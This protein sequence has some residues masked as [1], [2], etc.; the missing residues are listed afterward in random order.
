M[1]RA[2]ASFGDNHSF[3]ETLFEQFVEFNNKFGGGNYNLTVA[4]ELR[5]Q[6]IQESIT[7]NPNFS[8]IVP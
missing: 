1:T 3:N 2:D 6:R 7:T 5:W 4:A 8:F